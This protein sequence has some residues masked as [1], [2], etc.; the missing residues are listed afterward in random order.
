M[1]SAAAINAVHPT[2]HRQLV[3]PACVGTPGWVVGWDDNARS[4]PLYRL[5]VFRP[6]SSAM[7]YGFISASR[8]V[9][10]WW[11]SCSLPRHHRQPRNRAAVGAQIPPAVRQSDPS[12]PSSGWRQVASGWCVTNTLLK[13][14][15]W[16]CTRDEG[17]PL[18]AGGQAQASNHCKLLSSKAMV[19]LCQEGA[20][21]PCCTRDE[22]GPFGAVL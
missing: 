12:S 10:A 15:V 14:E 3:V 11:R 17:R 9:S 5:S 2:G 6:R 18:D 4:P 8:L 21:A 20:R 22:G 7:P 16:C 19:V 1:R 13:E